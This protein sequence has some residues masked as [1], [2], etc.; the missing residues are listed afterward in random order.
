MHVSQNTV[1][2]AV[3]F[4]IWS[5]G[6]ILYQLCS[7]DAIPLFLSG[8]DDNLRTDWS[9]DDNLHALCQWSE[10]TKIRKLSKVSDPL[11]KNLISL[12]L[13]KSPE[14]RPSIIKIRMHPF[15]SGKT[16]ARLSNEKAKYQVF[17]SYRVNSDSLYAEHLYDVLTTANIKVFWDKKSLRMGEK[18]K[19]D[20]CAALV[21]TDIFLCIISR[22]AINHPTSNNQNYSKLTASSSVDN[23][24]LEH[25]LALELRDIGYIKKI[26]PIFIGDTNDISAPLATHIAGNF[27]ASGCLPNAPLTHV[28]SVERELWAIMESQALGTPITTDKTVA[29]I[30]K[31]LC[32]CQGRLI[33]GLVIDALNTAA[34]DIISTAE[35]MT[36]QEEF[37]IATTREMQSL[38]EENTRLKNELESLNAKLNKGKNDIEVALDV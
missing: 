8:Q 35:E 22:N 2:A 26:C 20:F 12:M 36:K 19:D 17:I 1:L 30:V 23:V 13:S 33:E 29:S 38:K 24:L 11:A 32:A 21:S 16:V 4:D 10:E 5:L 27:F 9:D 25:R 31:D 28:T 37:L 14:R 34:E 15:L 7:T 3:S 18:W 6:V